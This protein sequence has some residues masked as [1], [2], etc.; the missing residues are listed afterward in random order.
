MPQVNRNESRINRNI[1]PLQSRMIR[2]NTLQ[3]GERRRSIQDRNRDALGT[4]HVLKGRT[5]LVGSGEAVIIVD[6]NVI[7]VEPPNFTF[8]GELAASAAP[9]PGQFPIVTACVA[10]WDVY[11]A[12]LPPNDDGSGSRGIQ[13]DS[14]LTLRRWYRGAN[15]AAIATGPST[16][17]M[18]IHWQFSGRALINPIA[19]VIEGGAGGTL[20]DMGTI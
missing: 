19:N 18:Y 3:G 9:I 16:Q 12:D 1:S 6:F 8:G 15:I 10:T 4:E 13:L 17:N 11:E 14:G 5:Q 2:E 7:F 20:E